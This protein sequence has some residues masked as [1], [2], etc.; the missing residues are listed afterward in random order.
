MELAEPS[1]C[2]LAHCQLHRHHLGS[3]PGAR[4][5]RL[6]VGRSRRSVAHLVDLVAPEPMGSFQLDA[7]SVCRQFD[8]PLA[9]LVLE[10]VPGEF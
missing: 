3:S 1:A 8:G 2:E 7:D 4:I 6:L 10:P 5:R 9:P